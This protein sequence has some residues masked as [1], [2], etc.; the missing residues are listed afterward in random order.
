ML[1]PRLVLVEP[2]DNC[3]LFLEYDTGEKR[4]FDV[5]PYTSGPWYEELLNPSHFRAVRMLEGGTGIE[6]P[7]GQDVAPHELYELSVPVA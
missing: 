2:L 5:S 3:R 4:E 6:W 7:H 1:Q